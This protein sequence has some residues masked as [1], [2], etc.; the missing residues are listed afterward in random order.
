MLERATKL[1]TAARKPPAQ[2]RNERQQ[3]DDEHP[4]LA[5]AKGMILRRHKLFTEQGEAALEALKAE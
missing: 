4:A 1:P 3:R 2:R 5:E